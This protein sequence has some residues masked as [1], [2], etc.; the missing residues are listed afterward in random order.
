[1]YSLKLLPTLLFVLTHCSILWAQVS[2]ETLLCQK[3]YEA[4]EKVQLQEGPCWQKIEYPWFR[5]LAPAELKKSTGW[6]D[7]SGEIYHSEN[8][9]LFIAFG[10]H[11][12]GGGGGLRAIN[13]TEQ[14]I[15]LDGENVWMWFFEKPHDEYKYAAGALFR[16][17]YPKGVNENSFTIRLYSKNTEVK[18]LAEKIFLS[19]KFIEVKPASAQTKP[20]KANGNP[21]KPVQRKKPLRS[22]K[23]KPKRR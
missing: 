22:I 16:Y 15:T 21:I 19:V 17:E 8:L 7:D 6:K 18:Y 2:Q 13:Y 4:A 3:Q 20:A 12:G 9:S 14:A 1:M 5:I 23:V 11:A 10:L